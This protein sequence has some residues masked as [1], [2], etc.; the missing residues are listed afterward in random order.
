[1]QIRLRAVGVLARY[2]PEGKEWIEVSL[3]E[4]RPVQEVLRQV[5]LNPD[6]VASVLIGG[7]R[8]DKDYLVE[9]GDEVVCLPPL[10]GG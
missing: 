3:S 6:L 1:M 8:R 5:G 2:M 7:R 4:A 10:A 9:D